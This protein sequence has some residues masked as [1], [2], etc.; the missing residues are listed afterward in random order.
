MPQKKLLLKM[1]MP[2]ESFQDLSFK[3][4]ELSYLIAQI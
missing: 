2:E 4:L 1:K 3:T